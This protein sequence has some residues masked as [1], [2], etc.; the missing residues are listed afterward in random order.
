MTSNPLTLQEM[1][2]Q[3]QYVNIYILLAFFILP[4]LLAVI[5]GKIHGPMG[6][7]LSPW[8]FIYSFIV[9]WVC[10]PG[11]L[12]CV[13]TAYLVFFVRQNLLLT[14]VFSTVVPI[15]AMIITLMLVGKNADWDRLPGVDRL[16]SLMIFLFISF[17]MA[18]AVQKT[19]IWIF[20]GG[21]IKSLIII[22]IVCFIV[23]KWSMWKIFR[24]K[25]NRLPAKRW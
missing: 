23:L 6:G 3:L 9:Y 21:S 16:Y 18:L 14:N 20:F 15:V 12:A 22:V 13:L 17:A 7:N 19:R 24:N 25:E 2:N 10:I 4:P 8:K 5:I 1:L 11:M